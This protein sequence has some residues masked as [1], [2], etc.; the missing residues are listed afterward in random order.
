MRAEGT[1][2][3]LDAGL[4]WVEERLPA[5]ATTHRLGLALDLI[6]LSGVW[7]DIPPDKRGRAIRKLLGLLRPGGALALT[8]RRGT[9]EADCT[10]HLVPL[11]E[12]ERLVRADGALV[13]D[14]AETPDHMGWTDVSWTSVALLWH[15]LHEGDKYLNG[16]SAWLVNCA[17]RHRTGSRGGTSITEGTAKFL[18]NRRM[19]KS[20][21]MRWSRRGADLLLQV[22]YA[23]Y[24]GAF[25]PVLAKD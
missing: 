5:L 24:N 13:A 12:V 15:A 16:Q 9:A 18:V 11:P 1:R 22:R 3:H 10:M 20:Q 8:L 25:G 14:T 21:Q 17:K 6:L 2:R 23:V 19:N 4:R 7:Q